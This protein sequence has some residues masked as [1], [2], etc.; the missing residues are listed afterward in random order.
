M[1][2]GSA[3][4]RGAESDG[5]AS[6]AP[7]SS[8]AAVLSGRLALGRSGL[9]DVSERRLASPD[10]QLQPREGLLLR[11]LNRAPTALRLA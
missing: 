11:A 7:D 1:S 10:A 6:E 3:L 8:D 9:G 5:R 2:L 4:R